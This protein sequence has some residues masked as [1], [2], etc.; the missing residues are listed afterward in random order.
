MKTFS[1]NFLIKDIVSID[2]SANS[3]EEAQK[4][5]R[6]RFLKNYYSEDIEYIDGAIIFA[7]INCSEV[8]AQLD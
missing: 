3:P 5:A 4:Q 1:V 7:G 2:V 8:W 6:E